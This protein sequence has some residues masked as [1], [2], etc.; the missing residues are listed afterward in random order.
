MPL[1]PLVR[2]HLAAV[3]PL[4]AILAVALATL[5]APPAAGQDDDV[6]I[7]TLEVA[8]GV[9]MLVGAGGNIGVSAGADGVFLIDDQYAPLS[10]A[11][12]AAVAAINPGPI[13]FILNTHWHPDH[14]GGNESFAK[15][16]AVIVAHDNVRE[17][18][19]HEQEVKLFDTTVPASPPVALPVITFDSAVTFW[20]NGDEI[21]AHHVP[22]AHTDGDSVVHFHHADVLHA[23]DVF[24]NGLYP[25]IDVDRGGS[26]D[27]MIEVV[28]HLASHITDSTKVIPGHGPLSDRAG[29]VAYGEMLRGVRDAVAALTAEGKDRGAVIAAKPTAPWDEVWGQSFISPDT[30]AG[31]VYDSLEADVAR[32]AAGGEC[33]HCDGGA[34]CPMKDDCPG[35]GECPMGDE[36]P[37]H[38]GG[39]HGG[40]M[41]G[42]GAGGM[43]HG[44]MHG[45]GMMHG[46]DGHGP[47]MMHRHGQ[48]EVAPQDGADGDAGA[49]ED[50]AVENSAVE[51]SG[52]DDSGFDD[53]APATEPGG[54]R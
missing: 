29:L 6:K 7:Q 11:V 26:I 31:L 43:G 41:H 50:N 23:G 24:F 22:P 25:V 15:A 39:M 33:G 28:G 17:T 32:Q 12:R 3:L 14:T 45:E 10:D 42:G 37:M 8:D 36:C 54:G 35:K 5:P 53:G 18:M 16:G 52:M 20:L 1:I 47:G 34:N 48:P 19:S 51:D 4:A 13:R 46:H 30:F 49:V 27:G 2:R 21:R 9:W 38:G 44:A 40:G